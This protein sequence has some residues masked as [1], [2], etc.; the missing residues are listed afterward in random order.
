MS[1]INAA[2]YTSEQI[3]GEIL[4][5]VRDLTLEENRFESLV[6]CADCLVSTVESLE[7]A[8]SETSLEGYRLVTQ[9]IL[10][11]DEVSLENL[12]DKIG[13]AWEAIKRSL[14][15]VME[16]I[17]V[18]F[19]KIFRGTKALRNTVDQLEERLLELDRASASPTANVFKFSKMEFFAAE[20]S[21]NVR[22]LLTGLTDTNKV[23]DDSRSAYLD[24][25]LSIFDTLGKHA[26]RMIS[27]V[28]KIDDNAGDIAASVSVMERE[29]ESSFVKPFQR[30]R[31]SQKI[32]LPGGK[33][34]EVVP[35]PFVQADVLELKLTNNGADYRGD[36]SVQ[37]ASLNELKSFIKEIRAG[38]RQ[39]E[40]D[41]SDTDKL[42]AKYKDSM[43]KH[44]RFVNALPD[45]EIG[46]F[47]KKLT[48]A[49]TRVTFWVLRSG[50]VSN[51]NRLSLFQY[52]VIRAAQEFVKDSMTYYEK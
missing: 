48:N 12:K 29:I 52:R 33:R 23:I 11:E 22:G 27:A 5:S 8:N 39:L 1:S 15:E 37:V 2:W 45:T 46:E 9:E 17:A 30:L 28:K 21:P 42:I 24:S 51:I 40:D 14:R 26:D 32:N 34:L 19:Q 38:I 6:G 13:K 50:T 16:K 44:D 35:K 18:Y 25:A 7:G 4:E 3:Y 31:G 36:R 43:D 20:Q 47:N 49:W 41:R 10:G